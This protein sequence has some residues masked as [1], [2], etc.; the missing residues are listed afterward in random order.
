MF[1]SHKIDVILSVLPVRSVLLS[2]SHWAIHR[3]QSSL[4]AQCYCVSSQDIAVSFRS[5]FTLSIHIFPGL[6][7]VLFASQCMTCYYV[8]NS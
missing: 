7:F 1:S 3:R 2:E 5:C 4:H 6:H 8:R